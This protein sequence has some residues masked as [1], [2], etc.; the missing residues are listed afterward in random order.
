M[1]AVRVAEI[2]AFG[3]VGVALWVVLEMALRTMRE[4]REDRRK[5]RARR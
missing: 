4:N 2:V 5:R 1:L 3:L